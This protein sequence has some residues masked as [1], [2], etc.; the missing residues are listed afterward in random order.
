MGGDYSAANMAYRVELAARAV[1]DLEILYR[2]VASQ[3]S[4]V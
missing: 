1:G 3:P 4:D 2:P